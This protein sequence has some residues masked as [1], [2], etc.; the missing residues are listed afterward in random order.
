VRV[1]GG[2]DDKAPGFQARAQKTNDRR[3]VIEDKNAKPT[4]SGRHGRASAGSLG[5]TGTRSLVVKPAPG[6]SIWFVA[7]IEPPVAS[8][9]LRQITRQ[10]GIAGVVCRLWLSAVPNPSATAF[11]QFDDTFPQKLM[12]RRTGYHRGSLTHGLIGKV[13]YS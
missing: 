4:R 8:M 9:K 10:S 2:G 11:T 12:S 1:G 13:R 3:L 5:E 6:R 7:V